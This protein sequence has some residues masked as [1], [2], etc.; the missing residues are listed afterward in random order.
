MAAP[1]NATSAVAARTV[2][3]L[4]IGSSPVWRTAESAERPLMKSLFPF[5][6]G[7]KPVS[8]A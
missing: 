2:V 5:R 1:A 4:R 8:Q 6:G 7:K 3:S